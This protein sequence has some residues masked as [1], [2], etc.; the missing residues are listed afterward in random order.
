MCSDTSDTSD[1]KKN[2]PIT[3]FDF[4]LFS[5]SES[6]IDRK[7]ELTKWLTLNCE[8]WVFQLEEGKTTHKRHYQGRFRLKSRLRPSQLAKKAKT[9]IDKTI[10][11]SPT[12]N[13][14]HSDNNFNYVMK[15]DTRVDGPWADIELGIANQLEEAK[16]DD[17]KEVTDHP[18]PWQQAVE[19]M[20]NDYKMDKYI[21]FIID[22]I[23]GNGKT[24]F[25]KTMM[26]K[27]QAM[28][29]PILEECS[30]ISGFVC[31]YKQAAT[32]KCYIIDVARTM[33]PKNLTNLI[34][35]IENIKGGE[36][37]DWRLK[38]KY[39]MFT[40]PMVIITCNWVFP[41]NKL[42]KN[43]CIKWLIVDRKLKQFDQKTYDTLKQLHDIENEN[44]CINPFMKYV[45]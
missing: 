31:S 38:A 14:V 17:V 23:G 43:R 18:Y 4:T 34:T 12:T 9:E 25:R 42:T 24:S 20:I 10:H 37:Y 30:K 29:V 7:S 2:N 33:S 15:E 26:W 8:H 3:S 6:K 1:T 21:H 11:V 32:R 13:G 35:A 36:V 19:Q 28:V 27:K 16:P 22:P 5:D 45:Q 39:I 44:V 40:P 41:D